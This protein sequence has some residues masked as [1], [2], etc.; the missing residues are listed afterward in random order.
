M[1]RVKIPR[2]EN[3]MANG[4]LWWVWVFLLPFAFILWL[5]FEDR[6]DRRI[7]K[8]KRNIKRAKKEKFDRENWEYDFWFDNQ[9]L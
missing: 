7:R 2:K 8:I 5:F 3:P 6:E 9:G 4:K 1:A